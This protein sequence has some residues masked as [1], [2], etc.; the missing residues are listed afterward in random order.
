MSS[1]DSK[2]PPTSPP[3]RKL[4][5]G[6]QPRLTSKTGKGV[7]HELRA[8]GWSH[9]WIEAFD[10][11]KITNNTLHNEGYSFQLRHMFD[12]EDDDVMAGYIRDA[13]FFGYFYQR[14]SYQVEERR[15]GDN[16]EYPRYWFVRITPGH[17]PSSASTRAEGMAVLT[18][19]FKDPTYHKF[20]PNDV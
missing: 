6:K 15:R 19:F 20:L 4:P 8:L 13:G 1:T 2:L 17:V 5:K 11:T 18:Q 12:S 9:L 3:A 10:Y 14:I 16:E 7:K